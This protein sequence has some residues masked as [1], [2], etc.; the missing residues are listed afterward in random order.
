MLISENPSQNSELAT[1]AYGAALL[2]YLDKAINSDSFAGIYMDESAYSTY[3]FQH[4]FCWNLWAPLKLHIFE[5]I[6][7][8]GGLVITN[9][10]PSTNREFAWAQKA[11]AQAAVR[12][13][14]LLSKRAN[15]RVA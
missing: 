7:A 15:T 9:S 11:G 8:A 14:R 12:P 5:T 1:N 3:K 6:R 13:C 10:M 4:K 2:K